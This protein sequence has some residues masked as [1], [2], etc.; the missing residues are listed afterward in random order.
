MERMVLGNQ[1]HPE[2][3]H[4]LLLQTLLGH[5][6]SQRILLLKVDLKLLKVLPVPQFGNPLW[7]HLLAKPYLFTHLKKYTECIPQSAA[8]VLNETLP[9]NCGSIAVPLPTATGKPL[10]SFT[11]ALFALESRLIAFSSTIALCQSN[12]SLPFS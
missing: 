7:H 3:M 6:Q 10:A 5:S 12:A 8:G 11:T 2:N 4:R 9:N 1:T